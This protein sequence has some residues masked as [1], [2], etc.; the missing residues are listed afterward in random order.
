[1]SYRECL[2]QVIEI[3]EKL[4]KR[5]TEDIEELNRELAQQRKKDREFVA[6]VWSSGVVVEWEMRHYNKGYKSEETKKLI[7]RRAFEYRFRKSLESY[8]EKYRER[9]AQ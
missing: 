7:K 2:E 1:M 9:L 8:N 5:S 6:W 4:I 3:N